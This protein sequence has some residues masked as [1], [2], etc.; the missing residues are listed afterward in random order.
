MSYLERF[1]S[2][3]SRGRDA[4]YI[5]KLLDD[6]DFRKRG[7]SLH[8]ELVVVLDQAEHGQD[9][10]KAISMI[11]F[12]TKARIPLQI[13]KPALLMGLK[14]RIKRS[15]KNGDKHLAYSRNGVG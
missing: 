5:D 8:Y 9:L 6:D 15:N 11:L 10:S 3:L 2:L 1:L 4:H 14:V 13:P 12:Q 7:Y